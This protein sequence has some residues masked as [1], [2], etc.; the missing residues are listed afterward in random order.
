MPDPVEPVQSPCVCATLRMATR[1]VARVYDEALAPFGLRTTQYSILARLDADGPATVGR[2]AGRLV[3]D[4]TT[5]AREAKPL[6]AAGLAAEEPGAD[7][8]QRILSLTDEGRSRLEAAGPGWREAQRHVRERLG[9]ERAQGLLGELHALVGT[10][11][12][13][14]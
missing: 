7:R 3:M 8:R 12:G 10:L 1:A 13:D 9:G 11:A 4:R 2:L 6:V 14:G 5:L